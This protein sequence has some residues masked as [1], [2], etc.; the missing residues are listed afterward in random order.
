MQ[1]EFDLEDDSDEGTCSLT[2]Q[3]RASTA[4]GVR[5]GPAKG[6]MCG[7]LAT[8]PSSQCP[9]SAWGR[10]EPLK[11][12]TLGV[13]MGSVGEE[14]TGPVASCSLSLFSPKAC[15]KSASSQEPC[16]ELRN[17][18]GAQRRGRE[19][20]GVETGWL[21]GWTGRSSTPKIPDWN[22]AMAPAL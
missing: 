10:K 22:I 15:W 3:P 17:R 8:P 7:V 11:A 1:V 16:L 21:D 13:E 18:Q 2:G 5:E 19:P 4:E 20:G 12:E 9:F 6:Q 14:G